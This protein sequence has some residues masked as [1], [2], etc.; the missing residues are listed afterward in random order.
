[1]QEHDRLTVSRAVFFPVNLVLWMLLDSQMTRPIAGRVRISTFTHW[2]PKNLKARRWSGSS[3]GS[4][5]SFRAPAEAH[6][7]AKGISR[8]AFFA[9]SGLRHLLRAICPGL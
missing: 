4:F 3:Y 1:M 8:V 2:N 6:S 7:P 9:A 5:A